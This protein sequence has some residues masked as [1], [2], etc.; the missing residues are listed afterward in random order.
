MV[1]GGQSLRLWVSDSD[2]EYLYWTLFAVYRVASPD[3]GDCCCHRV[4]NC[5]S[6][7]SSIP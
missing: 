3:G 6:T 1:R 5:G 7:R 2:R 4:P